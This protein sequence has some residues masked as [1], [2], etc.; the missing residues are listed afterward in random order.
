MEKKEQESEHY[1]QRFFKNAA[2]RGV[3]YENTKL[4]KLELTTLNSAT[5]CEKIFGTSQKTGLLDQYDHLVLM[6]C[7]AQYMG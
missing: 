6:L 3:V 2:R 1:V 7:G 5:I 4:I